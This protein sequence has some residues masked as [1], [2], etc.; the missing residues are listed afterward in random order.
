[1]ALTDDERR[2]LAALEVAITRDAPGLA[3]RFARLRRPS[4]SP[5]PW[6]LIALF[7]LGAAAGVIAAAVMALAPAPAGM[8]GAG[9]V[10][11]VIWLWLSV[12]AR[13]HG[14]SWWTSWSSWL[15]R[16]GPSRRATL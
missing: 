4:G 13:R 2:Q 12:A 1:M 7:L 3:R 9:V 15:D 16:H 14:R 11:I 6:R 8:C 5:T 10:V